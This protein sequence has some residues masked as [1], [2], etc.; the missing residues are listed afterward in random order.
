MSCANAPLVVIPR[1]VVDAEEAAERSV[2]AE[3]RRAA[4]TVLAEENGKRGGALGAG[5]VLARI[6]PAFL[7][8]LDESLRFAIGARGVGA[9]APVRDAQPR[10]HRREV[11]RAIGAAVIGEDPLDPYAGAQIARPELLERADGAVCAVIRQD[12]D[13][14]Q[15]AVII[16]GDVAVLVADHAAGRAIA[17]ALA[18]EVAPAAARDD[19]RDLLGVQVHEISRGGP[20]VPQ[21]T[22]LGDPGVQSRE[23]GTSEDRVDGRPG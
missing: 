1:Q 7:E 5:A 11:A 18:T 2:A 17:E 20:L 8:R 12:H 10:A 13:V 6:R 15:A 23:L 3:C 9:G 22:H 21:H 19:A 14:R 4:L 16:N